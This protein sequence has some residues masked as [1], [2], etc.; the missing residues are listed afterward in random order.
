MISADWRPRKS[1]RRSRCL[2]SATR[3]HHEIDQ[4]S[5]SAAPR[6]AEEFQNNSITDR[7]VNKPPGSIRPE[8]LGAVYQRLHQG[9]SSVGELADW[10]L[11]ETAR[12]QEKD[13][14]PAVKHLREDGM[15]TVTP[16][17]KITKNS[18]TTLR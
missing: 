2:S 6:G 9:P 12:W 15:V 10:L 3:G 11:R 7:L 8:L 14:I 18:L 16:E 5:L 17:G 13:A 1:D 4:K